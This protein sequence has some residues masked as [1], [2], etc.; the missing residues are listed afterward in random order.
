MVGWIVFRSSVD[1]VILVSKAMQDMFN[2]LYPD[3]YHKFVVIFNGRSMDA[4]R[5]PEKK[6]IHYTLGTRCVINP[7]KRICEVIL[8][9]VDLHDTRPHLRLHIAAAPRVMIVTQPHWNAWWINYNYKKMWVLMFLSPTPQP[10]YKISTYLFPSVIG[11][12]KKSHCWRLWQLASI[13]CP[14]FGQGQRRCSSRNTCA[15]QYLP[16]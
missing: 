16:I 12:I 4:F 11:R 10:G 2:E 15:Y 5:P 9:L 7:I 14:I 1:K 6:D 8:A 3:H 13:V